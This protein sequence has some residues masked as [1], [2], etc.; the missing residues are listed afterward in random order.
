MGAIHFLVYASDQN[1]LETIL[2]SLSSDTGNTLYTPL[3]CALI[4]S[5]LVFGCIGTTTTSFAQI[6]DDAN[7]NDNKKSLLPRVQITKPS[8]CTSEVSA[9]KILVQGNANSSNGITKVEAFAH[10]YPFNGRFPF[11][12]AEPTRPGNWSAWSVTLD[13]LGTGP[14]RILAKVTDNSG[15]EN[16]DEVIVNVDATVDDLAQ[17]TQE[18]ESNQQDKIDSRVLPSSDEEPAIKKRMAFVEPTFTDAAYNV[19]GFYEFYFKYHHIPEG[20]NVTTDLNLMTSEIPQEIDRRYF[21]P[22]VERL[23]N[24]IPDAEISII[25]DQDVHNGALLSEDGTNT[26]DVLL[27]LHNE[28]VTQKAYDSF[29]NF[30][31]N[32]GIIIF[33]DPNIF[34][35]EVTYD[36]DTCSITLVKGHDWEFDGTAVRKSVAERYF[37]ENKEW[38]GSNFVVRDIRDQVIFG[39]NPFNYTHFEE[40]YVTNPSARILTEYNATFMDIAGAESFPPSAPSQ[41]PI[42]LARGILRDL[43]GQNNQGEYLA[44]EHQADEENN[45]NKRI[46]TYELQHGQGKVLMLGIYGQNLFNNTIFLN[47]FDN[48]ILTRAIGIPG[49][50]VIDGNS[51]NTAFTSGIANPENNTY[52]NYSETTHYSK[53]NSGIVDK[54]LIDTHSKTLKITLTRYKSV[55]DS[56][57]ILL[58]NSLIEA[59]GP[60][61]SG[62]I[63]GNFIVTVDGSLSTYD[64]ISDDIESAFIIPLSAD[65]K[66]VEISGAQVIPEFSMLRTNLGTIIIIIV[67]IIYI[68]FRFVD[69]RPLIGI[70][71]YCSKARHSL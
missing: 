22:F 42:P 60:N 25:R 71:N 4:L 35:A 7:N 8:Y 69:N 38:I 56:L 24:V 55:P 2:L 33:I 1:S 9:G 59:H 19:D 46:A 57:V 12:P 16:W 70:K 3:V 65:S 66:V 20:V 36:E 31:K 10:S 11:V 27:L 30:V 18:T 49:Q 64:Q 29:R 61:N 21:L 48:I 40:N 28:Y 51:S 32:G 44:E 26:Y 68:I 5:V 53:M 15:R 34:Y 39:N 52:H 41:A 62:E 14:H 6:S 58:P 37:E 67:S 63:D 47:F 45:E 50:V 13:L 43:L 17:L 54:V 23:K